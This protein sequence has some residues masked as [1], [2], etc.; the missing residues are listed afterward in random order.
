MRISDWSSHVCSSDLLKPS[1]APPPLC[2]GEAANA[3]NQG[4]DK[5]PTVTFVDHEG[6]SRTVTVRS[7]QSLMVG[8]VGAGVDGIESACGGACNCATCHVFV[9]PEGLDRIPAQESGEEGQRG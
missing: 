4:N 2:C 7:G 1:S 3:L 8:A 5:M 9:S 6:S